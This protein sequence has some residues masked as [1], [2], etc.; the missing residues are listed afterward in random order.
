MTAGTIAAQ[1]EAK[2]RPA[3]DAFPSRREPRPSILPRKDPVVY[4]TV[5][6][7]GL[8]A[9]AVA[10]YERDGFL[11]FDRFLDASTVATLCEEMGQLCRDADPSDSAVVREPEGDP[12][13]PIFA[14]HER[15]PVFDR[16]VRD[17]RILAIVEQL[18]G[19]P[20]YV[21]QTRI[22]YKS[23][24]EGEQFYWHSDFETWHTEDGMPRMR[25][26]SISIAL[27]ENT[28]LNGPLMLIPGSHKHYVTCVGVTPEDHFKQSLR[29]QEVGVPDPGSL[30]WL[31]ESAGRIDAPV[32]PAGSMVL[33]DCNTMHGSNSNITPFPRSN[34]FVVYNSVENALVAPFG[35][36]KPRPPFIAARNFAPLTPA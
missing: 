3:V 6:K 12:I 36:T 28:P 24:F 30:S 18:L 27:C 4:G 5:Q 31:A 10:Q 15:S 8:E 21:H 34:L 20:V 26:A 22:N 2:E 25:A 35:G 7:G 23:G 9:A 19:G 16:I 29:R 33:F 14:V 17:K 13:R 32:G 11:S 1:D